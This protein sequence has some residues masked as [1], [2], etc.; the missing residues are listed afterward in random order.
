[1]KS[2]TYPLLS[3]AAKQKLTGF[4]L[5]LLFGLIN[6]TLYSQNTSISGVVNSYFSV[7][8]IVPSKACV[9]VTNPS[10][11]NYND[12]VMLIQMKGASI[13]TNANSSSF[14][15]TTSLNNAG[16]YEIGKVCT[17]IGDSV[18]LIYMLLN[19]YTIS[20]KVQLVKI[21]QYVSATVVDTL[22]AAPWD[23]ATGIGGVLAV[24]VAEDLV[25]N[26]PI[27][28]DS[29][30]FKGGEFLLSSGDCSDFSPA[31]DYAYNANDLSPQDGAFK[32]EGV[33]TVA[34]SISGGRGAPASGG[35]G[36]NNHNNSGG[37]GANLSA[38]GI[39]GGN[40]SSAG[41]EI[42]MPGRAGKA[43]GNYSGTKVF[44][45]GGGG[46]G[47]TNNGFS[48]SRGGGH[49]GGIIF[50]EAKNL[51]GNSKK[52]S[53]DGQTGGPSRGDGAGGGGAAGTLLM[54]VTNYV[55]S[56]TIE[57]NGGNGG[58]SDD[59]VINGRCY[60]GGGGG[61][62]GAI[63]FSGSGP[64]SGV[65]TTAGNGG[66]E[67]RRSAT[68]V[69]AVPGVAGTVGQIST[70]YAYF[71]STVLISNYCTLLLPVEIVYFKT[72]YINN[73]V[74]LSWQVAQPDI[75][76]TYIIE[77]STD[78]Y[79]WIAINQQRAIET[80]STYK[81]LDLS[82]KT[83]VN[84]YRL[85]IIEHSGA[86]TYSVIQK[87][88]TDLPANRVNVYPNPAK[89][90]LYITG[91]VSTVHNIWL[92]D[93][94]GKLLWQKNITP[95]PVSLEVDLP[96]LPAGIYLLKIGDALKKLSIY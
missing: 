2:G 56:V 21:P 75:V 83:G 73:Q 8:E 89:N 31:N 1:M 39:G 58:A 54:D 82:P 72:R 95:S 63:Y 24:S 26:E 68:C 33:A 37:G 22:K 84:Y 71:S 80:I 19:Q 90:K 36:G 66:V 15:D 45:G 81:D 61:S 32:G 50:I 47:H 14:G 7:T 88:Y 74:Q 25:L 13:N 85:K 65:T 44:L 79:N 35:G 20:G 78:G 93:V 11:L 3:P 70:S 57:A 6:S 40:S 87:V 53:A 86:I 34:A 59:G 5:L 18:F 28:A 48:N 27:S 91:D 92:L 41:C 69:T 49:G 46:A 76:E 42:S 55:G 94:S 51:V 16:N 96:V 30:G 64:A 43:L 10:G 9:R 67:S 77:R 62:G 4:A 38:G 12:K 29:A 60:G 52:I 17:V 23:N